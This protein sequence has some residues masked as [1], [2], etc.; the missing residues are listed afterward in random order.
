MHLYYDYFYDNIK[1]Y[2]RFLCIYQIFLVKI[3]EYKITS[4]RGKNFRV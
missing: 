1:A 2:L 3:R 4:I